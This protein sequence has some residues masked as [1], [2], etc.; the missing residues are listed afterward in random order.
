MAPESYLP[1]R[2]GSSSNN[3]FSSILIFRGLNT[4]NLGDVFDGT[5]DKLLFETLGQFG[6]AA[7]LRC[8]LQRFFRHNLR[9][10]SG[11]L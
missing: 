5:F 2:K 8:A 11:S 9:S 1:K 3:L 7:K 6:D 4:L 10:T